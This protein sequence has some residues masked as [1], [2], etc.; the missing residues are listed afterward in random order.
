MKPVGIAVIGYG[1]VGKVHAKVVKELESE[2]LAKLVWIVGTRTETA[3]EVRKN[4][5]SGV[6]YSTSIIDPLRD[7]EVDVVSICTPSY[8]HSAQAIQAFEY[9]KDVIVEKP[10]ATSIVAAKEMIK[11][12]EKYGRRLGVV[13]QYRYMPDVRYLK[14]EID[15]GELGKLFLGE[16]ELKWYRDEKTYYLKDETARSWR[17]MWFTEGGGVLSNQGI[18]FIDLLIWLM[19][20]V[21]SVAGFIANLTHPSIEVED[22]AVASLKFKSG[23]LGSIVQTLSTVP[24]TH[25]YWKIRVYGI[26]GQAEL[27]NGNLTLFLTRNSK[28]VEIKPETRSE[29]IRV[30]E[31]LHKELYRDFLR[32]YLE[33]RP[34]PIDGYEGY[35]SLEVLKA[36]YLSHQTRSI[37]RLPLEINILI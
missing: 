15:R 24:Q 11:R 19:G 23:A 7:P 3:E 31:A 35:K 13:F 8:L 1:A 27:T 6:R 33:G 17:G 21:D 32:A 2:G 9:R 22:T 25:Q 34:F 4:F 14:Q 26:E 28:K 5:G 16:V 10:M 29:T 12:A 36:V 20:D 37:V 30:P 18:H